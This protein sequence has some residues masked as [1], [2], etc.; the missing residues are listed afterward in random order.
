[1][2]RR[3]LFYVHS[4]LFVLSLLLQAS[5]F[6][7]STSNQNRQTIFGW[8]LKVDQTKPNVSEADLIPPK[9]DDPIKVDTNLVVSDV[10]VLNKNGNV[11]LGLKREDF[12]VTENG[13]SKALDL[14]SDGTGKRIPRAIVLIMDYSGSELPYLS[15]SI[16]A[17]RLL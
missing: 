15:E 17:A 4:L 9:D 11:I 12:T 3:T 2:N 8:S 13:I 10:L 1:M 16:I 7:Q 5:V 6:S 14:F